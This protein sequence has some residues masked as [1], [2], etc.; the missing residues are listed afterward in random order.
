MADDKFELY[1]G[2]SSKLENTMLDIEGQAKI[3]GFVSGELKTKLLH[4]GESG[5]VVGKVDAELIVVDGILESADKEIT[6]SVKISVNATGKIE[7]NISYN[8]LECVEGAIIQGNL[9]VSK[10][11]SLKVKD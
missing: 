4:I 2:K 1:V 3:D 6:S 8:S 7:G 9:S 10:S 5:K 11:K